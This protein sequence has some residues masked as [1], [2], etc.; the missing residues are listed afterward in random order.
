MYPEKKTID[1]ILDKNAKIFVP[2]TTECE[3]QLDFR[4]TDEDKPLVV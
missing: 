1:S 2:Y 4:S 3:Y